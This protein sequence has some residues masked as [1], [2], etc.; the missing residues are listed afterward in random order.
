MHISFL[1][2]ANIIIHP[3]KKYQIFENDINIKNYYTHKIN[4]I[5]LNHCV[6]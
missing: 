4:C 3:I 1:L 2:N 5:L 6:M